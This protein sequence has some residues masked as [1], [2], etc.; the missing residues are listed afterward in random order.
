VS[1]EKIAVTVELT[2]EQAQALAQYLKR[3]TWTDVRQSA[4]DDD[5]AYLMREA[6]NAI[7]HSLADVGYSPR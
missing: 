2:D 1:G 6:F 3:Y 7:R 5:E 4:V